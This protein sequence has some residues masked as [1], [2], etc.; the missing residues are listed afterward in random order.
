MDAG[1]T[2][3]LKPFLLSAAATIGGWICEMFGGWDDS[4][5]TLIIFMAVDYVTGII[6]AAV[7]KKSTKTKNGALESK[8]GLKGILRKG[9]QLLIVLVGCRL[10]MIIG[11]DF[12][13]DAVIIAIITNE[14][15]SITEN[16]GRMGVPIPGIIKKS[17]EILKGKKNDENSN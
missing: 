14:T 12:V 2:G 11:S 10:D 9:G 5:T 3:G 7:F 4:I 13:R 17:I 1:N 8:A 15:I 6:V 16:L